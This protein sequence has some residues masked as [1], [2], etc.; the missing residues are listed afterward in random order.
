MARTRSS[1]K[2]AGS[3][4]QRLAADFFSS[5][6]HDRR[7][8]VASLHGAK[9]IGDVANVTIHRDER[10]CVEVKDRGGQFF[11]AEWMAEAEAE[12][13]NYDALATIVVAKRRGVTDP[14]S[15]WVL[16]TMDELLAIINGN[17]DHVVREEE[18]K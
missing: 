14:G 3:R 6:M 9:D 13:K 8:D 11:A 7:I 2:S 4:M 1:A 15:Q 17:R 5:G 16:T 12:R 18:K 10:L